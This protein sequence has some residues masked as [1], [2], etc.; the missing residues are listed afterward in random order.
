MVSRRKLL[1]GSPIAALGLPLVGTGEPSAGDGIAHV[2][3]AATRTEEGE[4]PDRPVVSVAG[5]HGLEV[6]AAGALRNL[7]ADAGYWQP[8]ADPNHAP[9][10]IREVRTSAREIVVSFDSE[11]DHQVVGLVNADESL[12]AAGV[13]AGVSF[14]SSLA[15]IRLRVASIADYVW[16]DGDRWRTSNKQFDVVEFSNGVL[17]LRHLPIGGNG[18]SVAARGGRY[19]ACVSGASRAVTSTE[20]RIE[21][22]G[23]YGGLARRPHPKMACSVIRTGMGVTDP[24]LVDVDRF[25]Y[26]N[27]WLLCLADASQP[28]GPPVDPP[29]DDDEDDDGEDDDASDL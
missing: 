17:H 6:V 14:A 20:T 16:Y 18:V 29:P 10:G 27:L 12:A 15:R 7:G 11:C 23:W 21:F 25:P 1:A 19:V 5:G 26:S 3:A 9:V 2:V 8:I 28:I 22:R 13:H 4:M 24:R